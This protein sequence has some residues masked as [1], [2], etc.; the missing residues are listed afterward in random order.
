MSSK[1]QARPG[2]P[3]L[4]LSVQEACGALGISWSFW[5]VHVEP[6]VRV[7]R[8][9]RRKLVSVTELQRWLDEHGERVL[10]RRS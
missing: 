9:G 4:A 2:V 10:E 7:V 5:R 3:R 8:A 6:E 1:Q